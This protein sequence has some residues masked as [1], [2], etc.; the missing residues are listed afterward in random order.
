MDNPKTRRQYFVAFGRALR[1]A[2]RRNRHTQDDLAR[3][4]NKR[5]ASISEWENGKS[6]PSLYEYYLIVRL[7]GPRFFDQV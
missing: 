7:Y 1:H 6:C 2:R 3:Y 5:R 4:L